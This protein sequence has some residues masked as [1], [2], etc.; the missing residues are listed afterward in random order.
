MLGTLSPW[1]STQIVLVLQNIAM[2]ACLQLRVPSS[3]SLSPCSIWSHIIKYDKWYL[4][5]KAV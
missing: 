2:H 1:Y 3:D 5:R 4:R